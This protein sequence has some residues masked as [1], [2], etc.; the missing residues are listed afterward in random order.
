MAGRKRSRCS[1][2]RYSPAGGTLEVATSVTPC[3][4]ARRTDPED[5]RIS[6]VR[7]VQLIEAQHAR[8]RARGAWRRCS[9]GAR[10]RAAARVR[11]HVVHETVEVAAAL[12]REREAGEE[13][14]HEPGLAAPDAAPQVQATHGSGGRAPEERSRASAA[15]ARRVPRYSR[16]RRSIEPGERPR[17]GPD[18]AEARAAAPR[19]SSPAAVR[20]RAARIGAEEPHR[21]LR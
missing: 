8:Y 9:S 17:A 2:S 13:K 10:R 1:R 19:G 6:D 16:A 14:I 11:V 4:A 15:P 3:R 12:V 20:A 21:A 18:L 7:D 5:H